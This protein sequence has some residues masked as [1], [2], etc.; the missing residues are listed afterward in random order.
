MAENTAYKLNIPIKIITHTQ[1]GDAGIIFYHPDN[2]YFQNS[3]NDI[4]ASLNRWFKAN[5]LTQHFD[6]TNFMN[7]ATNNKT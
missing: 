3:I 2:G 1:T 5:K 6:R 4:F 7:F